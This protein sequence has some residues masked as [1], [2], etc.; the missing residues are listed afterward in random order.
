MW[1]AFYLR[2][3]IFARFK[4]YIVY[5]LEKGNVTNCD[6]IIAKV[7]NTIGHYIY[8][9]LQLFGDLDEIK[10]AELRLLKLV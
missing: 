3:E 2:G 10:T 5:Y 8:L 9:F 1:V 4:P 7:V 6:L